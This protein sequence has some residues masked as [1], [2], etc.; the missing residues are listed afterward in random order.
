[1]TGAAPEN[2][3]TTRTYGSHRVSGIAWA[4]FAALAL[5]LFL[6]LIGPSSAQASDD[7]DEASPG[8][9]SLLGKIL[10]TT[11]ATTVSAVSAP[12]TG[13]VSTA[14]ENLSPVVGEVTKTASAV[15][16]PVAEA[17][18][19]IAGATAQGIPDAA[20]AL[21]AL[22]AVT[23]AT[24]GIV[25]EVVAGSLEALTGLAG[26]A[27]LSQLTDPL[28]G[29]VGGLPV[30]GGLVADSGILDVIGTVTDIVDT[31]TGGAGSLIE[32]V[33]PPLI[34]AV[35]P[36]EPG[37]P[38]P[39]EI[40]SPAPSSRPALGSDVLATAAAARSSTGAPAGGHSPP[41]PDRTPP[42]HAP[43][44]TPSSSSSS[45]HAGGSSSSDGARPHA[46][47]HSAPGDSARSLRAVDDDLP[48]S[49]VADSDV[50]P[51]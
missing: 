9:A 16:A 18:T 19:E 41:R 32:Q 26:D 17:T 8:P 39:E 21:S 22:G 12:V 44:A 2:I 1:M 34:G 43:P 42:A 47:F 20:A 38:V 33:L 51:D 23:E 37:D 11:V 13:A 5:S 24:A 7:P 30:V 40:P 10:S 3:V 31:A 45:A 6:L 15:V 46:P 29:V 49:P 50:S 48:A 27:P 4:G 36:G 35:T 25:T 14:V 28:L